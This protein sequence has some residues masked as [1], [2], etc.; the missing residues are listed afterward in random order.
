MV[1]AF[2]AAWEARDIAGLVGLLDPAAVA[3]ADGGG[4]VARYAVGI[5]RRVPAMTLVKRVVNGRPG[6][7]AE[8]DGVVETVLAG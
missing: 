6:L 1:R 3:V 2:K 4:N 7:V 8:R 5:T